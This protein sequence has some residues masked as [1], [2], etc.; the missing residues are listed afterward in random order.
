MEWLKDL[1]DILLIWF[2]RRTSGFGRELTP[3]GRAEQALWRDQRKR[4]LRALALRSEQ[5]F[6]KK[7]RTD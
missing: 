2:L 3:D 6:A 5:R 1:S 7:A 4:N